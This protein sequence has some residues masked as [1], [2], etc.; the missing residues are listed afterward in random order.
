[1]QHSPSWESNRISASQEIPRTLWN[2]KVHHRT[3]KC[4]PTVPILWQLDPV[5]TPTSQFLKIHLNIILPSTPRFS[6]W[7]LSLGFP[8]QNPVYTSALPHTC[9]MPRP[10]HSPQFDHP[11]NNGWGVRSLSSSLCS[12]FPLPCYIAPLRPRYCPQH[13]ILKHP[14]PTFLPHCELPSFT[15]VPHNRQYYSSVYLNLYFWIA[16]WRQK[17]SCTES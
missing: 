2:P 10:P 7:S 8:P 13:L 5:H 12:F 16:N 3:H 11:N 1:M 17:R 15:P 14:Q 6:K 4:P 9:Y